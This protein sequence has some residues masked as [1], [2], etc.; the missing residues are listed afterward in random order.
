MTT[1]PAKEL[2]T[3]ARVT[4]QGLSTNLRQGGALLMHDFES[5]GIWRV[6]AQALL[7]GIVLKQAEDYRDYANKLLIGY[8]L[9]GQANENPDMPQTGIHEDLETLRVTLSTESDAF[10]VLVSH[11][12]RAVAMAQRALINL[13]KTMPLHALRDLTVEQRQ[14]LDDTLAPLMKEAQQTMSSL[15]DA[16]EQFASLISKI[17]ALVLLLPHHRPTILE[18]SASREALSMNTDIGTTVPSLD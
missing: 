1:M 15:C 2:S 5:V 3:Y 4:L 11:H 17:K 18:D 10:D 12:H 14:R 6:S 8:L 16:R 13:S 7:N 9:S